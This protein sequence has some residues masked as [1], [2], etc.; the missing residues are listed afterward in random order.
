MTQELWSAVDHYL[1]E[2]LALSDEALEFALTSSDAA[3]LP[4]SAV[5]VPQ[6]KLLNLIARISGARR[7]LEIGT[8]GGYSSIWMAR[9]L[10]SD[11]KLITIEIDPKHAE[12][13]RSSIAHAGLADRV[14]VRLGAARDELPKIAAENAGPFD[15]VFIDAD[16]PGIP[17]YFT[18]A[19]KMSRSGTVIIVDNVVREGAVIDAMSTDASVKG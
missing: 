5:S 2:T 13:A 12:V 8:L 10:P 18:W 9:A 15:L 1:A 16:K 14:D 7:I 3:G 11:G 19:M 6:G 17:D 4:S